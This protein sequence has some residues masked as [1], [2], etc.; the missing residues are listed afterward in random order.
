MVELERRAELLRLAQVLRV[1]PGE[2][3]MLEGAD[4]ADLRAL[5]RQVW[6]ALLE[7]HRPTFERAATLA[8]MLPASM[9]A[10]IAQT[11]MGPALAARAAALLEPEQAGELARRLPPAFLADIAEHIDPWRVGAL[12]D[13]L[14]P[15]T[16]AAT[17]LELR[18]RE[19]WVVMGSF[20]GH[21]PEHALRPVVDTF[22]GET[23]L[24]IGLTAERTDRLDRLVALLPDPRLDEMLD[25]AHRLELPYGFDRRL[26][27]ERERSG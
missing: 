7:R 26:L 6:D 14:E 2:L 16:L 20:V 8:Q 24:R 9:A 19:R 10:K 5:R 3:R 27:A 11:A 4:P 15:A 17:A 25:A 22:D 18:R 12:L 1:E 13:S 21:L 23:M